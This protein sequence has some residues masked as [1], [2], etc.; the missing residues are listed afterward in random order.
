[1]SADAGVVRDAEGLARL[2]ALI[3]RLETRHGAALP[4]VVARL[5]AE[6]ALAR[7][8]SR[9]GHYRSDYPQTAARAVHT[10]VRLNCAPIEMAAE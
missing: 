3:E 7:H 2:A 10:R 4:L 8:E 9:G 6:A 1:M 5:I